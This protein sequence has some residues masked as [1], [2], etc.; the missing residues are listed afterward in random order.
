[1]GIAPHPTERHAAL[2]RNGRPQAVTI[3]REFEMEGSRVLMRREGDSLILSPVRG[4]RLLDLLASCEPLA[5]AL[6][7]IEDLPPQSR[8]VF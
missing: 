2:V 5:E 1:M 4:N 6:P 7:D 8:E 3:P